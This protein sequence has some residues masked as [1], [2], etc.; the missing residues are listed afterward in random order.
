MKIKLLFAVILLLLTNTAYAQKTHNKMKHK[1]TLYIPVVTPEFE[2]F[3]TARYNRIK[4]EGKSYGSE[5]SCTGDKVFMNKNKKYYSYNETPPNSFFFINKTYYLNGNIKR[6]GLGFNYDQFAKGTWYLYDEYGKLSE[7]IDYDEPFK[8]P[9][10][11]VLEFCKKEGIHF[12]TGYVEWDGEYHPSIR[13]EY[14]PALDI[15]YWEIEWLN[16]KLGKLE[17][18]RLDGI[19]GK[20]ISRKYMEYIM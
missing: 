16:P 12:K 20:E 14:K 13:R 17:I 19:T 4:K 8:F 7:T 11:K 5:I 18:I 9:F 10:E 6:K 15:C 1:E 3:D 2:I